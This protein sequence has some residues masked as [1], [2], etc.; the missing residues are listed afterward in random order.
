[1][2]LGEKVK[3]ARKARKMTQE[4]LAKDKITRNMLSRIEG[5]TANPSLD[6]IRHIASVLGLPVAY[7]LSDDDDLLFYEKKERMGAIYKAY[8]LKDYSYCVEKIKAFSE[9][10]DELAMLMADC[11][12]EVGK[13]AVMRGSLSTA[14]R[15]LD[16]ASEYA[17]KTVIKTEHIEALLPLYRAIA[18]NVQ[19]P[20]LEFSSDGYM[21]GLCEGFEY[22]MYKY[23]TQDFDYEFTDEAMALHAKAKKL[24]KERNYQDALPLLSRASEINHTE[25]YNAYLMFG[26]YSDM[27]FCYKQLYDFE[28]AYRY[29]TRRMSMIEGFKS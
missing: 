11:S 18:T 19:S 29:S 25:K 27:E 21:R 10:D 28:N 1:M 4:A 12:F 8:S 24:I 20:L 23:I 26:I 9:I 16:M 3:R 14:L 22:E 6:T 17:K 7:F 13:A 15:H 5:G 2:T